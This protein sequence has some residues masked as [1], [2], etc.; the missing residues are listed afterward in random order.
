MFEYFMDLGKSLNP[1]AAPNEPRHV[2]V[3]RQTVALILVLVSGL[4]IFDVSRGYGWVEW[5]GIPSY[6]TTAQLAPLEQ[7]A[8]ES[9]ED[10]LVQQILDLTRRYCLSYEANDQ[11][12]MSFAFQALQAA[13]AKY[14]A[15]TKREYPQL[16]CSMSAQPASPTP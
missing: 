12:G 11:S 5:A 2:F 1:K 14:F 15:L 8:R 13:R 10:Q 9:R 6:V 16:M 3:W 7:L 4:T